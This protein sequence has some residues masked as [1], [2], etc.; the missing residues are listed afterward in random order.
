ML[1]APQVIWIK[2]A[3]NMDAEVRAALLA[4]S[5]EALRTRTAWIWWHPCSEASAQRFETLVDGQ[6][7]LE[8]PEPGELVWTD[9]AA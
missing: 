9:D 2:A 4:P 7:A 6:P 8:H 5:A 3:A 1:A